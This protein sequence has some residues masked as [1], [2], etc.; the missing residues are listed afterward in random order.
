[1]STFLIRSTGLEPVEKTE[2]TR[3]A[4]LAVQLA[5]AFR[6]PFSENGMLTGSGC[7]ARHR[8]ATILPLSD[9]NVSASTVTSAMQPVL[10]QVS[11]A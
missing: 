10:V 3:A 9:F 11:W 5:I 1:M 8:M 2:N 6:E 7:W 4:A